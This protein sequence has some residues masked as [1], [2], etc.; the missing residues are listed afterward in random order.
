M[1]ERVIGADSKSA[2]PVKTITD[3]ALTA[4][5]TL[6]MFRPVRHNIKISILADE[7]FTLLALSGYMVDTMRYRGCLRRLVDGK[8]SQMAIIMDFENRLGLVYGSSYSD[9]IKK[10][11]FTAM[12][13]YLPFVDGLPLHCSSNEN[14]NGE[15]ALFLGLSGTGK[16]S[17][18]TDPDRALT[19]VPVIR[20]HS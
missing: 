6:N 18:S 3:N 16:T 10:L 7:S 13:Y 5:F 1:T 15:L 2:L 20:C 11:M 4:L 8:T 9:S 17:L 14:R 19:A 12:N